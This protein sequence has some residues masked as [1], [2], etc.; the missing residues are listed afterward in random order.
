EEGG[1]DDQE[2]DEEEYA[3]ETRDEKSFDPIPQTPKDSEDEGDGEEDL[4]LNV[5]EEQRHVEEEEEDEIYR[6]VNI[7]Q[8]RGIQATLEVE[9]SY[10]TLTPV[11]PDGQQQ[12]SSVS[13]QFVTSMLNLTLD[14]G[15]ESIFKTTSQLDVQTPTSVAPLPMTAT[16]MTPSTIVTITTRSQA[17]IL[18]TTVLSPIIQNL[19]SFGSL[20]GFDNR[21]R[22]LEVKFSEFRQTNQFTGASDHLHDEAQRENDEFLETV[23]EN[24]KKIIKEQVKEQ[25]K[26][27]P[28]PD[29]DWNKTMPAVH[30]SI[31]PW[32]SK[33]AKQANT[34]SSFDELMDTPLEFSNFLINQL[35]GRKRQQFYGFAVNRVSARDVYTKR[36]IIAVTELKI[37]EWHSYK[38]LD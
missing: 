37:V 25:V 6:D 33:L 1:D 2:Y 31:Q 36:R 4:G 10:V 34:H 14:V 16:T 35:K 21:L 28:S 9:D 8:G 11:N 5:G 27:P 15:M 18:P 32:I 30:K 29:R 13:S 22:T 19:P 26:K 24:I 20:F 38:H 23:D 3:E 12:S 7:N 17:P